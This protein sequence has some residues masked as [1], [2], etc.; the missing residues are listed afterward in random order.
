MYAELNMCLARFS[1]KLCWLL[2][3]VT[4]CTLSLCLVFA[5]LMPCLVDL[6]FPLPLSSLPPNPCTDLVVPGDKNLLL[7][8]GDHNSARPRY[9]YDS[10]AIFLQAALQIP[11]EWL[12]QG[13]AYVRK[14]PWSYRQPIGEEMTVDQML[15]LA[16]MDGE[17]MEM[18]GFTSEL[19]MQAD[20]QESLFSLLSGTGTASGA[21]AGAG[22]AGGTTARLPPS[23][24]TD[25]SPSSSFYD[26][27]EISR[28]SDKPLDV[29]TASEASPDERSSSYEASPVRMP[30]VL[31]NARRKEWACSTCTF[32]NSHDDLVCQACGMPNDSL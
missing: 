1:S 26:L 7:V 14:V 13:Q 18:A 2:G 29:D 10:I 30:P 24:L 3:C 17:D 28:K 23:E 19:E 25:P 22:G 5:C 20:L 21:S 6:A 27:E 31:V 8:E 9:V 12:L 11:Y 15:A 32:L 4:L 16:L